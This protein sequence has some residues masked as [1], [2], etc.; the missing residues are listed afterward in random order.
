MLLEINEND[1]PN[2]E[3]IPLCFKKYLVNIT[4]Q[5]KICQ[6]KSF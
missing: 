6:S 5:I 3:K 1:N 4:M 2:I